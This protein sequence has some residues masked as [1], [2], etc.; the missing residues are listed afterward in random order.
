MTAVL[1]KL[2]RS[3]VLIGIMG[4]GKSSI[5]RRLASK[6]GLPFV[7][8]DLEIEAAAGCS[9]PDIFE[10]HGETAFRE[11]EHRVIKRLL[12]GP[13]QI[14]ATGGGA[15]M[16]ARTR[17]L[18]ERCGLSIWLKADLEVLLRRVARRDNRPLLK[19]GDPREI[20]QELMRQ[21]YP[22]Y[23]EAA[24]TIESSD[25]PHEIVVDKIIKR[26]QFSQSRL[27]TSGRS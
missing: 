21:R 3:I 9:I 27:E 25:G 6:L 24:I 18:I 1:S 15:Y 19:Q 22:T 12:D 20:M 10:S 2:D 4:A 23:A 17:A 14:V 5:G 13:V 11:G 16:D 26:L 8:A 7:D